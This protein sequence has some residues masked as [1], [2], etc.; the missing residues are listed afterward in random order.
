MTIGDFSRATRLS[1][2]TLRF[3]HRSGVL[4]PVSIDPDNG[5]RWYGSEQIAHAQVVR[6]LR[7]LEVPVETIRSI[8]AAGDVSSRN[9]LVA[10]HLERLEERL[11]ATRA[12]VVSLR[13]LL[14]PGPEDPRI[15]LRT[16][17]ATP[18]LVVRAVI[19]L[20]DL[21]AW[22]S[23]AWTSLDSA[24]A[25]AGVAPAGPRGGIWDT[26]LFLSERGEAVL[27][28]PVVSLQGLPPLPP[29]VRGEVVP[30]VDVAVLTHRGPE[31]TMAQS[32]GV[33]GAYVADHEIGV[34]GPI[35]ESYLRSSADDP[36]TEIGWPV[37][38]TGR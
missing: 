36:V 5:Y 25:D 21:S 34:D 1:A 2:K 3:Y 31:E 8:L 16:L 12:A 33:L 32:Y 4:H 28:Q 30:G 38:R 7:A 22:Y 14:A 20:A 29:G 23:A 24:A 15:E 26:E 6:Q 18:A 35:R 27:L 37:F 11:E 13:G 19:D 17:P 10:Q 9:E